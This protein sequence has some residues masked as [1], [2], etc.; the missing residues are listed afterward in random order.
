MR[1]RRFPSVAWRCLP[2]GLVL[3]A[4]LALPTQASVHDPKSFAIPAGTA[5]N[6]LKQFAAQSGAEVVYPADLVRG[7]RTSE[8]RGMMK[9]VE[10]VS[11]LLQGTTLASTQNETTGAFSI[12]RRPDPNGQRAAP[13][14]AGDRP[15]KQL[16]P[17]ALITRLSP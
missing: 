3:C 12:S 4:L 13:T 11:R 10:A 17:E 8:V 9:P 2:L 1:P 14:T 7:V 6:S 15:R 16:S 5:E